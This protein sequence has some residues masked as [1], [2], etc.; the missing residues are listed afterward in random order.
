[1]TTSPAGRFAGTFAALLAAHQVADHWIQTDH[2]AASK[3]APGSAGRKACAAHVATYTL[4]AAVA[5]L[6]TDRAARLD[7]SPG[8]T[9]AALALSAVTH[10][11]ADRRTPLR[12]IAERTGSGR[13]YGFG[14]PQ[15]GDAGGRPCLGT[16]AYALDQSWHVGWLWASALLVAAAG[17]RGAR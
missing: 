12:K 9:V 8:R 1:M 11:I 15:E 14:T 7:L 6:A 16:G 5:V 10:Y 3:G 17:K 13:F 4:T 2:Q